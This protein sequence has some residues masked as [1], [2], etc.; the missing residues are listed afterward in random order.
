[1]HQRLQAKRTHR[2]YSAR[3]KLM[4]L[5]FR[6]NIFEQ[7]IDRVVSEI[8]SMLFLHLGEFFPFTLERMQQLWKI[9]TSYVFK[10]L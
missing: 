10:L 9:K 2:L 5:E 4:R 7:W 1:M 6:L 3:A 8:V